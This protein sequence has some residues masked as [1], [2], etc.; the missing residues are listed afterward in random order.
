MEDGSYLH[1]L[2]CGCGNT[3][4]AIYLAASKQR[5]LHD[6][7]GDFHRGS[8]RDDPPIICDLCGRTVQDVCS[9]GSIIGKP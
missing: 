7:D 5:R 6:L 1:T 3:G 8:E 4:V 9:G 2:R